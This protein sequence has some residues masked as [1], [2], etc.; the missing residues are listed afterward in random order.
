MD[1]RNS[2]SIKFWRS[3]VKHVGKS[4]KLVTQ[5][6]VRR[7]G[8][9]PE[10]DTWEPAANLDNASSSSSSSIVKI[11]SGER[12]W[13][14]LKYLCRTKNSC[15]GRGQGSQAAKAKTCSKEE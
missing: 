11:G 6:L 8:F 1:M 7:K 2:K 10:E 13:R 15:I 3:G 12:R 4:T 9:G 5:F 14:D